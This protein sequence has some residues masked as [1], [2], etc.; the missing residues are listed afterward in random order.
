MKILHGGK[1]TGAGRPHGTLG[2][3][4]RTKTTITLPGNLIE[5]LDRQEISRS[6]SLEKALLEYMKEQNENKS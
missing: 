3:N 1:R 2:K 6:K 5:W 4:N